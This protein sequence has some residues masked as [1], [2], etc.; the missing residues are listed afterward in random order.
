MTSASSVVLPPRVSRPPY[1]PWSTSP[2]TVCPF[3]RSSAPYTVR[4]SP[5]RRRYL[6]AAPPWRF[7]VL[8]LCTSNSTL[9]T[10]QVTMT[11]LPCI[12]IKTIANH[13]LRTHSVLAPTASESVRA[14]EP[15]RIST[16][17]Q[18]LSTKLSVKMPR[19]SSNPA[20]W[21]CTHY[22]TCRSERLGDNHLGRSRHGGVRGTSKLNFTRWQTNTIS[23]G[24]NV[25][26]RS[27]SV[28]HATQDGTRDDLQ[29]DCRSDW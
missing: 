4:S 16:V 3:N 19:S 18:V 5:A 27:A 17:L 21:P 13:L 22:A 15:S 24:A 2:P 26:K 8:P 7:T 23:L 14:I 20:T 28:K 29:P 12:H 6:E 25:R 1:P 10:P 11:T 9:T